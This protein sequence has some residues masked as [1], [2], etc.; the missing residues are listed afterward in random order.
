[1][2]TGVIDNVMQML[3]RVIPLLGGIKDALRECGRKI[4]DAAAGLTGVNQ[5]T[6][7]AA[8]EILN[9]VEHMGA[10]VEAAKSLFFKLR[11]ANNYQ[12]DLINQIS[13]R[14]KASAGSTLMTPEMSTLAMLL[15]KFITSS[16]GASLYPALEEQFDDMQDDLLN[17]TV[18]LQ[19]QDITAQQIEAARTLIASVHEELQLVMKHFEMTKSPMAIKSV[20]SAPKPVVHGPLTDSDK[21]DQDVA[22]KLINEWK[23]MQ[24]TP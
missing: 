22:D 17:I 11:S 3:E 1:M 7:V 8:V 10:R 24:V 16:N 18:T 21:T 20:A 12:V 15:E 9:T 4:P 19:V 23:A 5:A 14:L 13:A 6:E 2:E